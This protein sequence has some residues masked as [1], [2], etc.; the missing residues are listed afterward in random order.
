MTTDEVN[1][2]VEDIQQVM[3]FAID[4]SEEELIDLAARHEEY[5]DA[6]AKRLKEVE[7]L[8]N[9]GLR[10]EAIAVAEKSPSLNDVTTALDF[11]EFE[12]WNDL[13]M[14]SGIQPIREL[15]VDIASELNDAYSVSAPLERLLQR[16]RTQSLGRAPLVERIE[17]LRQ[18]AKEDAG[19]TQWK[20]DVQKF[21]AH[22]ITLLKKDLQVAIKELDITSVATL[23]KELSSKDWS[24]SV[25]ANV[26]K[27]AR[28]AHEK[29]R[30]RNAR[31]ELEPLVH[32]LSDAYAAFDK[33]QATRLQKRFMALADIIDLNPTD[34]L[35]DIAGP[36]LDWLIEEESKESADSDF[37][38]GK[39]QLEAA[40]DRKTTI[41]ELERLYAQT[42]RHG[43]NLPTLLENRLADRIE[44]LK[45]AESRKRVT[46]LTTIV[47]GSLLAIVAVVMIVRNV[48]FQKA[49]DGHV[50]Q[51][52]QLLDSA[53]ASGDLQ[54]VDDYFQRMDLEDARFG[55]EP[56]LL[57]LRQK[58]ESVRGTEL[59]RQA[60]LDQLIGNAI[61]L[62][63]DT[64]R[65]ENLPKAE[66]VLV[67]AELV[68]KN[69]GEKTRILST[70]GQVQK[71]RAELQRKADEAF[72]ADQ[73]KLIDRIA[74][75]PRDSEVGYNSV[76]DTVAELER[77]Q[78]VS[79]E[80][81]TSLTALK[82]KVDQQLSMVSANLATA[83]QL[84]KVTQ[85]A[86]VSADYRQTLLDYAKLYPGTRRAED[87]LAIAK[88]DLALWDNA[89]KWNVLR[90][91]LLDASLVN[92][93][94]GDAKS[95]LS[96]FATV[97]EASSAY[98]G[99]MDVS[100]RIEALTAI[101]ARIG[102]PQ[103]T[104]REQVERMFAPLTISKA[105]LV[106]ESDGK[107]YFATSPPKTTASTIQFTY[108][109]T[110]TGTQ[111]EDLTRSLTRFP[112]TLGRLP[113]QWK[114][115]QSVMTNRILNPLTEK[116]QTDFEEAIF[117][118]VEDLSSDGTVD[119][120]L[121]LLLIEK[122]L[123][124]GSDGSSFISNRVNAHLAQIGKAGV[125]RLTNWVAP[126]D[127]RAD[128]ERQLALDFMNQHG[129]Q[130]QSDLKAA[131]ADRELVDASVPGP[132]I[133][134]VGWLHQN[135]ESKW[136]VALREELKADN[137]IELFA[138]GR[139]GENSTAT[140]YP[141]A[142]VTGNVFGEIAATKVVDGIEGHPV[143]RELSLK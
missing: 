126:E 19:H 13:L 135:A 68:A 25:P 111:T 31:I 63:E 118:A 99:R 97:T 9:K 21:E 45:S 91:K 23:D 7:K 14:Q 90:R 134:C 119:S 75:L 124:I 92:T 54:P 5:V 50:A 104:S 30:Q 6:V 86:G 87:F 101:A 15:P 70:R 120:I 105:Y 117:L 131:I 33:P 98:P 110:T 72:E 100:N 130:I 74:A 83:R 40:L 132:E 84:Q 78:H 53:A 139:V 10:D 16:Y 59:G 43:H 18:L 133:Q 2:L 52:S 26:K 96:D 22:R 123:T 89:G 69:E 39:A 37:S 46:L 138:L 107:R 32:Q 64:P 17:T 106:Q 140:F 95:L 41:T 129:E 3:A 76:Q 82:T 60:Q 29:L 12:A 127:Q 142:T 11:P 56:E 55:Q 128:Q 44:S 71:V 112:A 61:N 141:V 47:G 121:R 109:T 93:T 136:V 66:S 48:T 20:A 42:V 143:Y 80:L 73:N 49:T 77:R 57:G 115:P 102:G 108:F 62:I 67:E 36:A 4:A 28:E 116:M 79:V 94:P 34:P 122:L 103:G 113:D 85:A 88:T 35:Y 114:A 137:S 8:L 58:L 81:R 65:W 125:S 51:L 24:V 1:Q 27:I 38:L